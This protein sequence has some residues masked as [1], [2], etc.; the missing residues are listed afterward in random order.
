MA[1]ATLASL[2]LSKF[3]DSD[4]NFQWDK[5]EVATRYAMRFLDAVVDKG[6]FPTPEIKEWGKSH[7][8]VGLGI[9][10]YA[11]MLLMQEI[12]YGSPEALQI[13]EDILKF[14]EDVSVDESEKNG[15]RI[16]CT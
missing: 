16:R 6:G 14:M 15:K 5:F 3:L 7:R 11:D 1:R 2:D 10:G 9:M 8:A 4:N 12:A 13:L